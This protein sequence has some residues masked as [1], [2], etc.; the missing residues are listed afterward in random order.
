MVR[1]I[2]YRNFPPEADP[3]SVDKKV[4][5]NSLSVRAAKTRRG[6]RPSPYHARLVVEGRATASP[7]CR[8]IKNQNRK[9]EMEVKNERLKNERRFKWFEIN[10]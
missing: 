7:P 1:L 4:G 9:E 3:P 2:M 10:L 5:M 8:L 6:R